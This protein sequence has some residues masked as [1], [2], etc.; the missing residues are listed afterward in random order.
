MYTSSWRSS[1]KNALLMCNYLRCQLL[2]AV[3]ARRRHIVVSLAKGENV[4]R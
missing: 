3:R 4:S 2:M 1:C